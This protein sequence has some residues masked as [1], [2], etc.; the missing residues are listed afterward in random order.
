MNIAIIIPSLGGGGAERVAQ[1]VGDYYCEK[2][3]TVYYFLAD[4]SVR[5]IYSVKGQIV[6]TGIKEVGGDDA[7]GNF[8]AIMDMMKPSWQLRKLKWK[9]HIDVAIS[10]MERFNYINVLSKGKE[11]VIT[12]ICTVLSE[13]DD[14][15]GP[16]YSKGMLRFLY[17]HSDA[18][19]V[20]SDYVKKDMYKKYNVSVAKMH[21]IPN[22]AIRYEEKE[23]ESEWIYGNYAVICVGRLDK[24]KQHEKIIRAFSYVKSQCK[25]AV[26]IILGTGPNKQYLNKLCE[27]Y[28]IEDSVFFIGFTENIGFYL[29]NSRVFVMASKVEGFP[30]SMVEAMAYG[31][32]VVTT[33]SPGACS[34]IVGGKELKMV[35]WR[36]DIV[37]MAY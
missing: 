29:K 6:N 14:V 37:S 25:E 24:I 11:K 15:R 20:M 18:V 27:K 31:V 13:R 10:F 30:N 16:L 2:G 9:Y 17:N 33:D 21:K 22:P 1:I 23:S 32:P 3:E 5:Q 12:R 7:P 26:L 36:F 8:L 28:D 19:V 4:N 35:L 34:E